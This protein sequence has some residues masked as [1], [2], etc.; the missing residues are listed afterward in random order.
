MLSCWIKTGQAQTGM[1]QTL[2]HFFVASQTHKQTMN[3]AFLINDTRGTPT[4][5]RKLASTNL[6]P[7]LEMKFLNR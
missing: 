5:L 6:F 1:M 7:F 4:L 3:S 2:K